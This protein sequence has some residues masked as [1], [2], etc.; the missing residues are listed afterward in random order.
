LIV[1]SATYQ[2]ASHA[3]GDLI[4]Q[5]PH[6]RLLARQNRLRLEAEA[7][8]DSALAAAGVLSGKLKGP[9]VFPPQPDGVMKMTRNPNRKWKVSPGED[10]YRRGLYTYF[11]RSTPHPFLKLFNAPESNT[12]CTRRDRSNTPLQALTLLN[13]EAFFEAAQ[14]L[15]VRIFRESPSAE[16]DKQIAFAFQTCLGRAPSPAEAT[17]IRQLLNDELA[18]PVTTDQLERF[19]PAKTLPDGID[20]QQLAAWTS[21]SRVLLNIDEFISR[22]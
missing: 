7:I 2:Q 10:R 9:S 12:T 11:W 6:N 4:D 8:R 13:D 18:D 5:D 20:P 15:A 16:P 19:A 22:E 21:V 3:R 14:A 1:T 17:A